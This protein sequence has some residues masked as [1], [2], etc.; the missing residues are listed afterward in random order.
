MRGD[1][2]R[3]LVEGLQRL[4]VGL[5][6][7]ALLQIF[8]FAVQIYGWWA[9]RRSAGAGGEIVVQRLSWA[10][11]AVW[12]IAAVT[13]WLG[14]S[15]GMDRLTDAVYP[16]WDGAIAVLSVTAQAMLARRLVENWSVWVAVDCAAIALYWS[17]DLRVTA[18]LYGLFLVM[19]V[20][21]WRAWMRAAAARG[22]RLIRA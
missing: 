6:S 21:G 22:D 4:G 13:I 9:W 8:F 1:R 18:L 15:T 10:G 2:G 5:A 7:D 14:W 16:F 11:R 12:A 3:R 17:R 19:S 20:L